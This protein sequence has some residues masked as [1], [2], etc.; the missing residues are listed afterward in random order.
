MSVTAITGRIWTGDGALL[1]QGAIVFDEHAIIAVGELQDVY[2]PADA[3]RIDA[4]SGTVIPGLCDVHVHLSTNSNPARVVDNSHF[5][6]TATAPTKLLHAVRNASRALAA[7]FTTLR[8]MGLRGAGEPELRSFFDEGLLVGPRLLVAPWW[9]TMTSG[10]GDLYYPPNHPRGKW[11]TADGVDGCRQNVRA[12]LSQGAD[13]V[14]VMASGGVMSHGD[15]PHWPNYTVTELSAIVDEAHG[16]GLPVAAHAHSL[17]GI[18]RC[19]DA[20]VDS[21]EHGTFVDDEQLHRMREQGTFLVPTLS[22]H[23]WVLRDQERTGADPSS[24]DKMTR[25]AARRRESFAMAVDLGVPIAMGTDSSGTLCPFGEHARELELYVE[26]G[27]TPE[28]ALVSATTS[29]AQLMR[30]SHEIGQLAVGYAPDVLVVDGDPLRDISILRD[31]SAL[32]H[33]FRGGIDVRRV[34][35]GAEPHRGL[36]PVNERD[37]TV[38]SSSRN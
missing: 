32:R 29:A 27:M 34:D 3:H 28:R 17:E 4:G 16:F 21:I 25:V 13:F 18:R 12:Q 31:R 24:I 33:I 5:R 38:L 22:I 20:G 2:I 10:H 9:I 1:E 15:E 26:H 8:A 30:R 7:G 11:D 23:D 37:S 14:K 36:V 6:S 35:E 19:L